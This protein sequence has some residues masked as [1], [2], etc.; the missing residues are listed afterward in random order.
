AASELHSSRLVTPIRSRQETLNDLNGLAGFGHAVP[1]KRSSPPAEK[2]AVCI[3]ASG[4][5]QGA[6][7][8]KIEGFGLLSA[9]AATRSTF[10]SVH[11]DSPPGLPRLKAGVGHPPLRGG[12]NTAIQ[13][14][15]ATAET[16]W[17]LGGARATIFL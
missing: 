13:P 8:R 15:K 3:G 4:R 10:P 7:G 5:S 9:V 1:S 2:W 16:Y 11:P 17:R 6:K 14:V 12:M